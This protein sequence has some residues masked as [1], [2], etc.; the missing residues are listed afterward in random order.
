MSGPTS[1]P[2]ASG[3]G[4][5]LTDHPEVDR[6]LAAVEAGGWQDGEVLP[7]H[8]FHCYG[9]GPDNPAGFALQAVAAPDGGV[10]AEMSFDG[11]FLGAPGLVHGGA[12]AGVLDD[13]F[14]MVL[15]RELIPAVT[16]DLAVRFRRPIHL[17][18]GCVLTGHL[19]GRDG[20]DVAM[21]A[22]IEQHD[23]VKVTAEATFRI[24]SPE[25]LANRYER[26]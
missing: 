25:R 14:G 4:S 23:E 19:V 2:D 9:C 11:R 18:V 26:T 3:G 22:A 10:R 6:F 20:K 8:G 21:R 24:I 7:R 5:M 13:V 1:S 15:V 17:D 16:T 12:L